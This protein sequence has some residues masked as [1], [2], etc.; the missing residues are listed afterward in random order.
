M[1][2]SPYSVINPS[3]D[4][5][6]HVLIEPYCLIEE[7]VKIGTNCII[8][9][10][11]VIRS[12]TVIGS[13][14][15]I[16]ENTVI[17]STPQDFN[18]KLGTISGVIIGDG[19]TIRENVTVHRATKENSN[20]KIG[21][22]NLLMVGTHI[23]HDCI[24]KND[25][26]IAN[27]TVMGGYVSIDDKTFISGNCAIHQFC[28]IGKLVM[29][30]GLAKVTQDIPPFIT[31]DGRPAKYCGLNVI[32][33]RR[34]KINPDDRKTVKNTYK[35]IYS[36]KKTTTIIN[37]LENKSISEIEKEVLSFLKSSKR[38]LIG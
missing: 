31:A 37:E 26:V 23:A 11:A 36:G 29:I 8:K 32:G 30:G 18:F 38:G 21:D 16:G 24:L 14:N 9:K 25:I 19:N 13:N 34:A 1:A 17:G 2:T 4:I 28:H 35:K 22:N 10:G 15:I 5:S 27:N 7:N 3:A 12:G 33:L 20:T 6:D